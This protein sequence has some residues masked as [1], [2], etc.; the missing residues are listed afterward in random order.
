M[1]TVEQ[2]NVL[3]DQE[4]NESTLK[5]CENTAFQGEKRSTCELAAEKY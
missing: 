3:D 1:K 2:K 4:I 5:W